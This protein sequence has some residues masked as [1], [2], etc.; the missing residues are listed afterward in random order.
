MAKREVPGRSRGVPPKAVPDQ[1]SRGSEEVVNWAQLQKH[2]KEAGKKS[3]DRTG[4]GSGRGS[5]VNGS[6]RQTGSG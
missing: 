2:P 1:G 6:S 3:W 5:G 4:R